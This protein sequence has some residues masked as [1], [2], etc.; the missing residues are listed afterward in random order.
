MKV[1]PDVLSLDLPPSIREQA[2]SCAQRMGVSLNEL[3][4]QAIEEKLFLAA[5]VSKKVTEIG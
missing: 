4:N 1:S 3:I 5:K 2:Y